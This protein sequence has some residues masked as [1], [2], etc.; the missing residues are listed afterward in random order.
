MVLPFNEYE[1][2]DLF[3]L[4][5]SDVP[6]F[7]HRVGTEQWVLIDAGTQ[8]RCEKVWSDLTK[9]VEDL[10]NI[11]HW[12]IT[13]SHYDHCGLLPL[14]LPR[15]QNVKIVT[16][17]RAASAWKKEKNVA[18]IE[19]INK[20]LDVNDSV[21]RWP[22]Y[23]PYPDMTAHLVKDGDVFELNQHCSVNVFS[24]EGHS[25]DQVAYE[26]T[27]S[28]YLFVADAL[29]EL[30]KEGKWNPLIFDDAKD[31]LLSLEK[32]KKSKAKWIFTGHNYAIER[33]NEIEKC[34]RTTRDFIYK[35]FTETLDGNSLESLARHYTDIWSSE[36]SSFMP[37]GLHLKSMERLLSCVTKYRKEEYDKLTSV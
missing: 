8:V 1:S 24:T 37:D 21:N 16:S 35:T 15:L 13:H 6:V 4:G 17:E 25:Q 20:L 11:S 22:E 31:Y 7:L 30:T 34:I 12:F 32:L 3:I 33:K 9:K 26:F 27:N 23:L 18:L 2:E 5:D 28:G 19:K 36:S 29:G 10:S 14:I